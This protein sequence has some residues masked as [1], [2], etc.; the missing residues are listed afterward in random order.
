VI[1]MLA[2][3]VLSG[4][5][6]RSNAQDNPQ[7]WMVMQDGS[8]YLLLNHQG[9]PRGGDEFVAP[10]WWMGMATRGA[11]GG[12]LT[13]S[14]MLSLDP[15]TVGARGYRELFQVGEAY[16]GMPIVDRQHP[17]DF[18]MQLAAWWRKPIGAS[19]LTLA[20]AVAGE[21]ALGPVAF[22]HRASAGAIPFAPLGHHTFDS[23]HVS[24]GVATLAVERGPVTVEGSVF[25]GR[26][27]DQQRW[28]IDF[29]RLD[30]V[31]GRVWYRPTPYWELQVSSGRLVDPEELTRGNVVRTTASAAYSRGTEANLTAITAG[32]G[33]NVTEEATRHAGFLEATRTR[34]PLMVSARAELVQVESDLLK[35]ALSH[36]TSEEAAHRDAVGGLTI[37]AQRTVATVRG[38]AAALGADATVYRVPADLKP[39]HGSHPV[40]AQLFVVIRPPAGHMGRMWNTRMAG[41]PMSTVRP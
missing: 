11:A 14:G 32:F 2:C 4:T 8:A 28:N 1:V 29:G 3:G 7:P 26:E 19:A 15:A 6:V 9:G 13:L 24:F 36:L 34:G 39:T 5:P 27:P 17:H 16:D 35:G 10:N 21:P 37:G 30:S 31:S 25:N 23:T 33:T 38:F 40:S 20:G 22:M 41:S 18:F 12:E